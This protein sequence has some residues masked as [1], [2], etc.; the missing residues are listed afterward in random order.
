MTRIQRNG[1]DYPASK[2]RRKTALGRPVHFSPQN[3]GKTPKTG[4]D[5]ESPHCGS[6]HR[7]DTLGQLNKINVRRRFKSKGFGMAAT[8]KKPS[9]GFNLPVSGLL[10]W[11]VIIAVMVGLFFMK[12]RYSTP[13][14]EIQ[15]PEFLAKFASNEV[16]NATIVS[17]NKRC[18]LPRS[19][20][21]F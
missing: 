17:T 18:P 4:L 19:T 20:A 8:I 21:I 6:P 13:S 7:N 10:V 3:R 16:A 1:T 12:G 11:T 9:G 2:A 14:K 15:Q 5:G